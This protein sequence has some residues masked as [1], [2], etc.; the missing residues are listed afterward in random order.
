MTTRIV[1]PRIVGKVG[2]SLLDGGRA[3][4]V[5]GALRRAAPAV[6]LV[7][8]PGGGR[9]V[10]RLRARHARGEISEEEAHRAALRVLDATAVRLAGGCGHEL[11]LT[12]SLP[13]LRPG[14][15]VLAPRAL[16]RSEDPMP[17][18]WAV[19]SDSVAAWCAVRA[20]ATDV[21]LVKSREAVRRPAPDPGARLHVRRASGTGLVDGHLPELL[22][23]APVTVWVVD[24]RR[25]DRLMG[26]LT[27]DRR[28]ATRLTT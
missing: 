23:D 14:V 7:L 2:G 12:A 5:V 24:G 20:G 26:W 10:D 4:A 9:A 1:R 17:A 3:P 19:T 15:S 22:G 13:P 27:G 8:V 6:D 16:L 21:L 11:P 25:P 28:A 18:T